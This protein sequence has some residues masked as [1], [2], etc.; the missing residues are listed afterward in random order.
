MGAKK[1][2]IADYLFILP[3]LIIYLSIIILPMIYSFYISLMDWNGIGEKK[4][5]GFSNYIKMFKDD[6]VFFTALKNNLVWILLTIIVVT[7]IS[8]G[9]ALLLN[10]RFRGR[11]FFRGFF[12]FPA[13]IAPITV[14]LI[15]RWIYNPFIGF[16]NQLFE[17]LGLPWSQSW[18]SD[19][20]V[21]LFAIFVAS[22]WQ[23][24]GQ[25]MIFFL[26]GLQAIPS[27]ILEAAK[28]DGA[29]AVSKFF[30][31]TVPLMK[32]TFVIVLATL[33][34]SAMKVYDIIQGL[35]AGGPNNATQTLATYMYSQTFSYNNVG[36]GTAL[37]CVMVVMMLIVIVPYV[38][39]TA[40]EK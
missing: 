40:K 5:I 33:I 2:N 12:Y 38:S 16:V 9:L 22:A 15:W 7:A 1:R 4:F 25:P 23:A 19:P 8:L 32:E 29:G 14:A 30:Y 37:S 26:A 31:V 36:Y 27:D 39:F 28:I 20:A 34:V 10:I 13:V 18:L 6:T 3:G 21:S 24:I 35:T 17:A 11:T